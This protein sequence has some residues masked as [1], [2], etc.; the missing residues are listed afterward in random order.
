M[1]K[2]K[3]TSATLGLYIAPEHKDGWYHLRAYVVFIG[4]KPSEMADID[5]GQAVDPDVNS[6]TIRN[7]GGYGADSAPNGLYLDDL[8]VNSQGNDD[9]ATRHLYGWEVE[10]RNVYTVDARKARQMA[11]TLET[12]NK[13]MDK[14]ET[15]YGRPATIGAY[16]LR[17]ADAIGATRM[18][19]PSRNHGASSYRDREHVI[20]DLAS[21]ASM[22][23][24]LVRT[25][26]DA[27]IPGMAQV[28]C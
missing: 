21:G 17:V 23:D 24:S 12:I 6:D 9:D 7:M 3:K 4:R 20:R 22:V 5:N 10:Y 15:K 8:Y 1:A 13:R 27:R 25:W 2:A 26:I 18:V 19:L 14:L 11:D 16:L 28:D